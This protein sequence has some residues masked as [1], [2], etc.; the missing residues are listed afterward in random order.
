MTCPQCGVELPPNLLACPSCRALIHAAELRE[1]AAK[2]QASTNFSEALV[3]WRRAL[4]L[5]PPTSAQYGVI[6]AKIN[7][8]VYKLEKNDPAQTV[9]KP[10][11]AN[12]G[13]AIGTIGTAAFFLFSKLKLILLG[14]TKASTFFS[15]LLSIGV[16][17]SLW[18][19]KFAVGFVVSI[20]IHEMGHVYQLNRYGIKATAPMFIPGLGAMIRLKQYPAGPHEEARVGL[21]GP[22]WGLFACASCYAIH[23]VTHSEIFAALAQAGAW[24][25]LF[26]LLPVWQLDGSHAFKALSKM[27]RGGIAALMG[28][29]FLLTENGL[30]VLLFLVAA[31]RCFQKDA[32]QKRDLPI[33]SEFAFLVLTLSL[34]SATEVVTQPPPPLIE[35]VAAVTSSPEG[36][37]SVAVAESFE[38]GQGSWP[39]RSPPLR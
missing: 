16:Y 34:L 19:W 12:K 3:H 35:S 23:L 10:K 21:A 15:M 28:V 18:G 22:M 7:D 1:L 37:R 36:R 5:L 9:Q 25:N 8:L 33:F 24:L 39:R 32:P 17:C 11:W 26:N 13:G 4:E 30:L 14:L 27:E 38:P 20:Y 29:M 31:F 6:N 2:A